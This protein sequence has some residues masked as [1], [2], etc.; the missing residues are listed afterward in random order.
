M[1]MNGWLNGF[2]PI[3]FWRFTVYLPMQFYIALLHVA[4]EA[5]LCISGSPCNGAL[6]M[7]GF[8]FPEI[9][10]YCACR[11]LTWTT[12]LI[13]AVWW[14]LFLLDLRYL[15][16]ILAP[17]NNVSFFVFVKSSPWRTEDCVCTVSFT[18]NV[19]SECFSFEHNQPSLWKTGKMAAW[20]KITGIIISHLCAHI[21]SHKMHD[22]EREGKHCHA[23]WSNVWTGSIWQFHSSPHFFFLWLHILT[24]LNLCVFF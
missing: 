24:S 9:C 19:Y 13:Q 1:I 14:C 21:R 16:Y 4:V 22:S 17:V 20:M 5:H 6:W 8:P 2:I 10:K 12:T 7:S 3:L 15:K 18:A 11:C 23:E